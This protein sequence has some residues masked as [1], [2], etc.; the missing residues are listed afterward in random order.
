V[1][2][3]RRTT[4]KALVAGSGAG[5]A[6]DCGC[7]AAEVVDDGERDGGG[8]LEAAPSGEKAEEVKCSRVRR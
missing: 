2:G 5:G 3:W 7:G 8:G 6:R 4:R 1:S